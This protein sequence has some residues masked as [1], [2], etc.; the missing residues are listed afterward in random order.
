ML[1]HI[2]GLMDKGS[3]V[4]VLFTGEVGSDSPLLYC[5]M[6]QEARYGE[7]FQVRSQGCKAGAYVLGESGTS[8]EGYYFDSGRYK[9]R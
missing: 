7:S 6:I 8:P 3:P 2:P 1:R 4:S 9:N 5:E